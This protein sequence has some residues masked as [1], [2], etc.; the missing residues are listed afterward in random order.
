MLCDQ[1]FFGMVEFTGNICCGFTAYRVFKRELM[2]AG[3]PHLV[4][5]DSCCKHTYQLCSPPGA[6]WPMDAER[7][8]SDLSNLRARQ[9]FCD[10]LEQKVLI[11][12][13]N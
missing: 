2:G 12:Q 8:G 11:S 7:R 10:D 3:M 6:E 13:T 5:I 4:K 1:I 9:I